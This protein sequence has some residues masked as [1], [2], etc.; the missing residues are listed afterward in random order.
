VQSKSP[1]RRIA[2][3]HQW[4]ESEPAPYYERENNATEED[5][6]PMAAKLKKMRL[7]LRNHM[8]KKQN[9]QTEEDEDLQS[10][11]AY[12]SPLAKQNP[13]NFAPSN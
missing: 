5:E 1:V 8:A 6:N 7:E 3:D 13:I 4:L 10:Y 11:D 9:G 12:K 2:D